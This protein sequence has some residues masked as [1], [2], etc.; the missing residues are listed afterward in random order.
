MGG[1]EWMPRGIKFK[2]YAPFQF[3]GCRV[4]SPCDSFL[5]DDWVKMPSRDQEDSR[6]STYAQESWVRS[7]AVSKTKM[8]T[9]WSGESSKNEQN[10][11]QENQKMTF[12]SS[13][14][15]FFFFTTEEQVLNS[16]DQ[17]AK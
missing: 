15:I 10:C 5:M 14:S 16:Q 17:S 1:C 6:H 3:P 8:H 2:K 7:L 12:K 4:T 13:G 11:A 9:G